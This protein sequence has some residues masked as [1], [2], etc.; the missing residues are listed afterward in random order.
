MFDSAGMEYAK[1]TAH[2]RIARKCIRQADARSSQIGHIELPA[3]GNAPATIANVH[4]SRL[5]IEIAYPP[6][7]R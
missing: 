5:E 6:A 2:Y 7:G 4:R 1:R 3:R